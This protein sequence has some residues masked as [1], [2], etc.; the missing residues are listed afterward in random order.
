MP[1]PPDAAR[2]A[3]ARADEAALRTAADA[4]VHCIAVPTPFGIGDVNVY[5]IEDDPLT[6]V[7]SGPNSA[8]SLL[9]VEDALKD[10]GHAPAD[11]ELVV[12][13]HQ[14][15]DHIGLA[16]AIR[17]HGGAEVAC[18]D[19]LAPVLEDWDAW[20]KQDD[21]DALLLMQRHGVEDHVSE[22]LRAVA[23]LVRGW[24]ASCPIDRP[25]ADGSVL[26][27][28]DRELQVQHRPGHSPSDTLLVDV[29]RRM[30]LV[31][32]HLLKQISSNALVSRPLRGWDGKRPQTLVTYQRSLRQTRDLDLDLVL[33]GH[34]GPITDHRA[35]IDERLAAN[36]RRAEF[37]YDKLADGPLTA[38]ELA[39]A[40][41]GNVAVTQAFLTLSEILG[42]LDLLTNDGTVIEDR[43]ETVIRFARA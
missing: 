25:L 38:H 2:A 29:A 22:A 34:R 20:G 9:A 10:L 30:A 5:L 21:D 42:H 18:L 40:T 27:L 13:T 12:V 4:G 43:S 24:G 17:A 32:D 35:L 41:W 3:E 1:S 7:D 19:D 16:H 33:G 11:I 6:L 15:A 23:D 31:G 36:D 39:I 26:K 37:L 8:T 14:H 28:R